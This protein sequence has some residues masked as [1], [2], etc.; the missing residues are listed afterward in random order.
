[1]FSDRRESWLSKVAQLTPA[2]STWQVS[3]ARVVRPVSDATAFQGWR[4]DA[5]APAEDLPLRTLR[6]GESLFLDFGEHLVG[7]PEFQFAPAIVSSAGPTLRVRIRLGEVPAELCESPS[8]YPKRLAGTWMTGDEFDAIPG[9]PVRFAERRAFQFARI[10]VLLAPPEGIR[11]IA[12]SATAQSSAGAGLPVLPFEAGNDPELRK[13]DEVGLRTLRN[14]MQ[15]VFEDGPKRDRRLWLG[16]L[17]LQALANYASFANYDLVKRCLYLFAACAYEDGIV[18]ACVYEEPQ[19]HG[20]TEFIPDYSLLYG[21]TLLD[22]A[23]ASD[24]WETARDLW[25][26]ARRQLDLIERYADARGL[27]VDPK[28]AW[29]FIDW[30]AE[31]DRQTAIVGTMIYA[32]GRVAELASRLGHIDEAHELRRKRSQLVTAAR[33]HLL[34]EASGLFVSGAARQ[35]SW[36]SQVWM[37]LADAVTPAE[38]RAI[39]KR[40]SEKNDAINPITPYLYHHV[41]EAYLH[42]GQRDQAESL[43]RTYWGKMVRLGATTFWEVFDPL[44]YT[45]SPYGSHLH[46]RYCHAWSC[47]PSYLLRTSFTPAANHYQAPSSIVMEAL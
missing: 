28:S 3:L 43:I 14:C 33:A 19:W 22:Y 38:G 26:V 27:F 40:L 47:T 6:V 23:I 45:L 11:V 46:N 30:C 35:V 42:C 37:I 7:L 34:D 17:R 15:G 4:M 2:I 25:P 24:D 13:I 39:L 12:C 9:T 29:L 21:P 20:G 32:L 16:D 18:A 5:E 8:D 36:A 41:V 31:L 10:D 44:V 1:M